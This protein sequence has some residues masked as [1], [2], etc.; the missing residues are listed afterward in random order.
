MLGEK[1]DVFF[2]ERVTIVCVWPA[3][4]AGSRPHWSHMAHSQLT[5]GHN[6]TVEPN[7]SNLGS[8]PTQGQTA[9]DRTAIHIGYG[10][11]CI[12]CS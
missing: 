3:E 12:E 2:A 4:M 7:T 10:V 8:R 6:G 11:L 5:Q 1:R 9:G